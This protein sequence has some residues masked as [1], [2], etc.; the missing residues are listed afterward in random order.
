MKEWKVRT[1][2]LNSNLEGT[3]SKL[4]LAINVRNLTVCGTDA[5]KFVEHVL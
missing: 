3:V 2:S 5:D 1:K 4:V